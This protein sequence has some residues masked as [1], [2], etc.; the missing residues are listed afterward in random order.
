MYGHRCRPRGIV[1]MVLLLT[2]ASCTTFHDQ[3]GRGQRS[4]ELTEYDRTLAI[5]RDLEPDMM[6]LPMPE[7][8]QYAYMR[9]MTDYRV[10]Y[11]PDARH[12]LSV[13]KAYEDN[14]PGVLP[15]DWKAR[16]NETLDELN[17]VVYTAGTTALVTS[18]TEAPANESDTA[19]AD[20]RDAKEPRGKRERSDRKRDAKDSRK[21]DA[22]K[23]AAKEP[24]KE[25]DSPA[26]TPTP[27]PAA[28]AAEPTTK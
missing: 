2:C 8:A 6:R 3:L 22:P 10:G 21:K 25:K 7:Q 27:P 9:G 12:W 15:P 24:S 23:D 16:V 26:S 1:G 28:K 11:K 18:R 4:F 17:G 13:A 5:L 19:T 20:K 14:S